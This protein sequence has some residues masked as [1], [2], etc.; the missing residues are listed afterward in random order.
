M[1][2]R[3][4]AIIMRIMPMYFDIFDCI[5][6]LALRK[7]WYYHHLGVSEFVP[8]REYETSVTP[9][10]IGPPESVWWETEP[11][12][13]EWS[14]SSKSCAFVTESNALCNAMVTYGK[15]SEKRHDSPILKP[16]TI[17]GKRRER[18]CKNELP[19]WGSNSRPSD[20]LFPMWDNSRTL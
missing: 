8:N 15:F 19:Q 12:W 20:E 1:E 6:L 14:R 16:L 9:L 10:P 18:I 2:T 4:R 13:S 17:T 11:F 7:L 5:V 3:S